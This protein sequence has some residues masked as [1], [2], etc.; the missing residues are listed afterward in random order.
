MNYFVRYRSILGILINRWYVLDRRSVA[1]SSN[2]KPGK[3]T[4]YI[5]IYYIGT[6]IYIY[7]HTREIQV[8]DPEVDLTLR[9]I[10]CH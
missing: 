3:R 5:Y 9:M 4:I 2:E 8:V 1:V 6:C 10:T 7:I